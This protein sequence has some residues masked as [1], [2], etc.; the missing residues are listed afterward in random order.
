MIKLTTVQDEIYYV[1]FPNIK[2]MKW[3]HQIKETGYTPAVPEGTLI[4]FVGDDRLRVKETP[5]QILK[6]IW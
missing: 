4:Y 6:L 3:V 5:E 1:N 2:Y